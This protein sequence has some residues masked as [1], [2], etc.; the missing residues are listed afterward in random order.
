MHLSEAI[1]DGAK[2]ATQCTTETMG[3]GRDGST[4]ALNA[5]WDTGHRETHRYYPLPASCPICM[6]YN[7]LA[8]VVIHLND[9]HKWTR[10]AIA[11]WVE[12][13][14][15]VNGLWGEP[16]KETEDN[17]AVFTKPEASRSLVSVP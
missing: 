13:I 6:R 10:E 12:T 2:L 7:G 11:E 8:V 17:E 1:R 5:A 16:A 3:R 9:D 4:C 14:E 15:R